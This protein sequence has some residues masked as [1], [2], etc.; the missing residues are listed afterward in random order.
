MPQMSAE[1]LQDIVRRLVASVSPEKV[2]LF[3]SHASGE[4]RSGSDIDILVVV[5]D[6]PGGVGALYAEA[7]RSLRGTCL[8]VELVICTRSQ[9]ERQSQWTSSLACTVRKKGKLLY[10]A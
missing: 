4:G 9:F 6:C 10:A 1:Q 3:G 8:P 7:E 2:Y 5:P